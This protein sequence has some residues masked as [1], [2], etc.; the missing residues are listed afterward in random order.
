M[1][2]PHFSEFGDLSSG[3]LSTGGHFNPFGRDHGAPF[4]PPTKRHV[5]DLGNIKTNK[6]GKVVLYLED[7]IISLI[8]TR[9]IIG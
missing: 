2:V 9:G 4:D 7:K 3:C 6:E 1:I 5:G 8:G